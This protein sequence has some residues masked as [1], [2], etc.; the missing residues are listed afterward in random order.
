MAW[1]IK[2]E[3]PKKPGWYMGYFPNTYESEPGDS[4]G[5]FW[6]D[7]R[8]GS[9]YLFGPDIGEECDTPTMWTELPRGYRIRTFE[10]RDTYDKKGRVVEQE[11]F[12]TRYERAFK[13]RLKNPAPHQNAKKTSCDYCGTKATRRTVPGTCEEVFSGSLLVACEPCS[14]IHP[15]EDWEDS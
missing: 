1:H 6:F 9:P 10:D 2:K 12:A 15:L 8:G 11:S 5:V 14:K 13:N 3:F 4:F 7:R